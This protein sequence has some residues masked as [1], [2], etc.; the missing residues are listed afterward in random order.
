MGQLVIDLDHETEAQ[1]RA[2][3]KNHGLS[4]SA[5]I[6]ER[7]RDKTWTDW[8]EDVRR[9]AGAWP[10]FPDLEQLR[11]GLGEDSPREPF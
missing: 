10:D 11:G 5:W 2:S 1:L 8:P 6:V 9:L 7:L 3:A 4:L